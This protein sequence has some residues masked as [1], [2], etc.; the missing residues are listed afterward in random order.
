MGRS[1]HVY[2]VRPPSWKA[3]G[4]RGGYRITFHRSNQKCFSFSL[5]PC[6][7]PVEPLSTQSR[8]ISLASYL[9]SVDLSTSFLSFHLSP[10]LSLVLRDTPTL[11]APIL[12]TLGWFFCVDL[13]ECTVF[14]HRDDFSD[15][16]S[17]R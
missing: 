6:D 2:T 10:P 15:D 17:W 8:P 1:A 11:P 4:R 5:S 7:R 9:F 13:P 16:G 14:S 12:A 3:P